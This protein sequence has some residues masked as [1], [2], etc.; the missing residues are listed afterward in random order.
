MSSSENKTREA[1]KTVSSPWLIGPWADGIL[2]IA[3]PLLIIP[4]WHMLSLA[5]SFAVLKFV[6]LSV[7]ATGHH[8]PGFIR[9]YTDPVVFKRFRAR[10]LVV[11]LLL[12]ALVAVTVFY[13]LNLVFLLL[14]VWGTW[15]GIMQVHGFSRIYDGKAGFHSPVMARLDLWV[16]LAWFI[17]V[18]LWSTGKKMSLLGTFYMAGGPL[19]PATPARWLETAWLVF[20]VAVTAAYVV[21]TVRAGRRFF[22]PRKVASL[23]VSIAFWA[24]CMITI[25]SLI[26]GL[27]L[28]EIFHDLQYNAFVWSYNKG[29]VERGLARSRIENFLFRKGW[30]R[31]GFYVACIAAYGCIG[32]LSQD[33]L[34]IYQ[35]RGVYG[36]LLSQV[37]MVFAA[38][39]LIHFY[40][41]GFIWKVRDATVRADLGMDAPAAARAPARGGEVRHWAFIVVLFSGSIALATSEYAHGKDKHIPGMP[42]N[43]IAL[44]PGSGYAHFLRAAE[45][46]G[47]GVLDSARSHYRAAIALDTNFGFLHPLVADLDLRLGD[48]AAAI[49]SYEKAL[50]LDSRDTV[51]NTQLAGLYISTRRYAQAEA[52]YRSLIRLA[53]DAADAHYGLAFSLLQQ[54]R[55]L[56]AKPY[57]ER[58]LALDSAQ[59]AALNY[60]GM[61]EH[62]T[63]DRERA[64]R[65]YDAALRL[66]PDYAHARENRAQL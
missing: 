53:P 4:A 48:T 64:R 18:I 36:S 24:Y 40:M 66:D 10:L 34:N 43:L 11:P 60:L 9:A 2:F 56:E 3:T 47:E 42:A 45:L 5:V 51:V 16:C 57:L 26:V 23:V 6:V 1:V 65:L 52:A 17:Q 29:R 14:I 39:A 32:F 46:V 12:I 54:R 25:E 50:R 33:T 27:L 37:G 55:G 59:P 8:L 61:V 20:T 35:N 58:S 62:A 28:W 7:S 19:L 21:A 44:I 63:G 41:D 30:G 49:A 22:N 38:S 13:K 15:H 31:V